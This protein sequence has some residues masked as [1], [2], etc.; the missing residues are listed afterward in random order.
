MAHQSLHVTPIYELS[1]FNIVD[2]FFRNKKI[3]LLANNHQK[4]ASGSCSA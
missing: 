4:S 2:K 1:I 3:T